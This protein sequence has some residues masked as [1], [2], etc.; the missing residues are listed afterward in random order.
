MGTAF[1]DRSAVFCITTS[2]PA[3]DAE[4]N[5][6]QGFHDQIVLAKPITKFAHRVV[7]AE[8]IPRLVSHAFRIATSG[9]PGPVLIDFPIEVLFAPV[10]ENRISWG[11][12]ASP[13][14]YPAGPHPEA[15]AK[16]VALLKGSQRPVIVTGTGA[17]FLHVCNSLNLFPV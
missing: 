12:L 8:E 4:T 13:Q 17:R 9:A 1:A 2:A 7:H 16:V 6:L 10:Q 5:V 3:R 14:A 15:I 11:S